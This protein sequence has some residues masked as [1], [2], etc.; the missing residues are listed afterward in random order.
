MF[1]PPPGANPREYREAVAICA[2]CDVRQECLNQAI[3]SHE[4]FGIW[5]GLS[6]HARERFRRQEAS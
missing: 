1:F 2:T 3:E 6:A 4:D 5:G